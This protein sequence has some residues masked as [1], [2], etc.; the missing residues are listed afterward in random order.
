MEP[1][2]TLHPS[3]RYTHSTEH[4]VE[5]L[6]TNGFSEIDVAACVLRQ[7]AERDVRGRVISCRSKLIARDE[8]ATMV[9][10]P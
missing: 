2:Y 1:E 7:E 9:A 5:M 8:Q 10:K 4:I 3:G 6:R